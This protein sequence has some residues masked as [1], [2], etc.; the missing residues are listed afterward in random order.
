MKRTAATRW[1]WLALSLAL[2]LSA[3]PAAALPTA[4]APAAILPGDRAVGPA[5]NDQEAASIAAGAD[6]YLVV[7]QDKRTNFVTGDQNTLPPDGEPGGQTLY[8]IYAARL[9]AAGRLIDTFPIVVA[10]ATW[11]QVRPRVAWNG[12]N[13]LVVWQSTR[14][15]GFT[16]TSD[17]LAARVSPSG[18]VLDRPPIVVDGQDAVDELAPAVASDG[19]NWVVV[20]FDQGAYFELDAARIAPTGQ[21][22]DPGGVPLYTPGFPRAPYN[23]E[24]AFAGDEFLLVW[25]EFGLSDDNVVGLRFTPALQKL[26]A[27]PFTISAKPGYER[28]PAVASDGASFFVAWHDERTLNTTGLY[29]AR[30]THAGQVLDPNGIPIAPNAGVAA[31]KEPAVAWDGARWYVAWN[32]TQLSLIED[33]RAARVTPAGVVL[34]PGGLLVAGGPA[35][36]TQPALAP[37]S[38]GGVQ[39]VWTDRRAG[40]AFPND[41]Y[42][43]EIAPSGTVGPAAPVALGA[44]A[45]KRPA[46]APSGSGYL[47]VFESW[48]SGE[49]RI[50]GQRLDPSGRPLDAEPFA[51][52][53]GASTNLRNPAVAWNGA[54]HLVVWENVAESQLYG[55]RVG[56]DGVPLDPAPLAIMPGNTP[57]VAALG[58]VFLVVGSHEDPPEI[59][60]VKATRVRGSDGAKLDPAPVLIGQNFARYPRVTPFGDRWFVVWQR[61]PTHDNPRSDI[62]ATFVASS[63]MPSGEFV[64][65]GDPV[66]VEKRPTVASSGGTALVVWH[67]SGDLFGRRVRADGALLGSFPITSAPNAQFLQSLVWNGS[68]YALA[69]EDYRNFAALDRPVSDLF[70]T[71]VSRAGVVLDPDGVAIA[72]D[73]GPDIEPALAARPDTTLLAWADF[74]PSAPFAAYRINV[75]ARSNP[76]AP[77]DQPAD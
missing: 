71:R 50:L 35:A 30:V 67:S 14:V 54:L 69:Y 38:G 25:Q 72:T 34:D 40:G 75:R 65:A 27:Q 11:D 44:P 60:Q 15:A 2:I 22:L 1:G 39:A 7:W 64:V 10:Q 52:A 33:V 9:D 51:I 13:W 56:P 36:E 17:V 6:G 16:R 59:R 5:P 61:H 8:D 74:I 58:D 73:P 12:Q 66:A 29:G 70:A 37:R 21:N 47:V 28:N 68:T 3:N 46:L 53:G 76:A 42:T 49:T 4:P 18:Q 77:P 57:D 32:D 23:H 63:G 41:L 20:W 45:Q 62:R 31:Y 19:T 43:A 55:R 24:L 48:T 26:D